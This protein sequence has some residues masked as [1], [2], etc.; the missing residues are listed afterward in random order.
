V[1]QPDPIQLDLDPTGYITG[2]NQATGATDQFGVSLRGSGAALAAIPIAMRAA[3]AHLPVAGFTVLAGLAGRTQQQMAP[4]KATTA[5]LGANFTVL[6]KGVEHLARQLPIGNAGAR[7]LVGTLASLG[8]VQKGQEVQTLNLAKAYVRLGAANNEGPAQL[9]IG[10]TQLARVTNTG[11]N[12]KRVEAIGDALTVV[13]AKSG[14][15][16]SGIL[17][18]SRLIAPMAAASGVGATKI[19]GI[20]AAFSKLGDDG[21]LGANAFN[22]MMGDLNRSVRDGSPMLATYA[23]IIG[24]TRADVL[25]MAKADPAEVITQVTEAVAKAGNLGPRM[26]EQLGLEGPRT[27]RV[28]QQLSSSGGLRQ[29]IADSVGGYGSGATKTGSD[30]ALRTLINNSE[31]FGSTLEQVTTS[32]GGPFLGALSRVVSI[33]GAGVGAV[34]GVVDS[35]PVQTLLKVFANAAIPLM[36]ALRFLGG[37]VKATFAGQVAT[38][39]PVRGL[40]GGFAGARESIAGTE[41]GRSV[42]GRLGGNAYNELVATG[43]DPGVGRMVG[44]NRAAER[45]G[46]RLGGLVSGTPGGGP[47]ILT[48]LRGAGVAA[49]AAYMKMEQETARLARTPFAER[50]FK[51]TPRGAAFDQFRGNQQ[52]YSY[53]RESGQMTVGEHMRASLANTRALSGVVGEEGLGANAR[54]LAGGFGRMAGSTAMSVGAGAITAG[55]KLLSG[56]GGPVG[57]GLT[58]AMFGVEGYQ[59]SQESTRQRD[60]DHANATT[61]ID[62]YRVA[63]GK[64]TQAT[65]TLAGAMSEAAKR[66]SS[67]GT[68]SLADIQTVAAQAGVKSR[69][70]DYS[71]MSVDA[72]RRQL[73]LQSSSGQLGPQ[74]LERIQQDLFLSGFNRHQVADAVKGISPGGGA[75]LQGD[76]TPQIASVVADQAKA[77]TEGG[78]RGFFRGVENALSGI[79]APGSKQ[80]GTIDVLTARTRKDAESTMAE[81]RTRLG[82]RAGAYGADYAQAQYAKEI[83][84]AVKAAYLMGNTD[85]AELY[86]KGYQKD[87]GLSN[88]HRLIDMGQVSRAGGSYTAALAAADKSYREGAYA[89][90]TSRPKA[91]AQQNWVNT[92]LSSTGNPLAALFDVHA[93]STTAGAVQRL[94]GP[95]GSPEDPTAQL[96]AQQAILAGAREAGTSMEALAASAR[97]AANSL[98]DVSDANSALLQ[99]QADIS[100]QI[101]ESQG[102]G[103]SQGSQ[104]QLRI[105]TAISQAQIIPVGQYG[106]AQHEAGVQATR[107]E[108]AGMQDTAKSLLTQYREQQVQRQRLQAD[109]TRQGVYAE[110]DYGTAVVRTVEQYGTSVVRTERNYLL[111]RGYAIAD[112]NRQQRYQAQDFAKQLRRAAEDGARA[113]Y[114]PYQRIQVQPTWDAGNMLGNLGEQ[115]QAIQRQL[116]N[117]GRLRRMGGKSNL[118]KLMGLDD[119]KNAQQ[120][121]TLVDDV[122]RDPH[123][124]GKLNAAANARQRLGGKLAGD[125]DNIPRQRAVE[126]QRIN[127]SRS[128]KVFAE[129]LARSAQAEKTTL[130]DMAADHA[131]TLGYMAD[132]RDRQVTRAVQ[133]YATMVERMKADIKRADSE[134]VD[135]AGSL[136]SDLD[137]ALK[138]QFVDFTD[139]S[140]S[141][142]KTA[143]DT[144]KTYGPQAAE[145][146]K[147]WGGLAPIPDSMPQPGSG[148][149]NTTSGAGHTMDLGSGSGPVKDTYKT[150]TSIIKEAFPKAHENADVGRKGKTVSGLTSLHTTGEAIDITPAT[151]KI[152]NWIAEHYPHSRELIYTPAFD[153]QLKDGHS[154]VYDEKVAAGHYDHIHW[155]MAMGGIATRPTKALIREGGSNEAIIP[156]NQRGVGVLVEAMRHFVNPE[157]VRALQASHGVMYVTYDHSSTHLDNRVMVEHVDL[158]A[159]TPRELANAL[160]AKARSDNL[161]AP[162]QRR[163]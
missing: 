46:A 66:L 126:D 80:K 162:P 117:L 1:T 58:A 119:P 136:T 142:I 14:A 130:A 15:S 108:Y 60:A 74:E 84:A 64:A 134:I 163:R 50:E 85:L 35:G 11:F 120:L 73:T 147:T 27:Q 97:G 23:Q 26:L 37:G 2:L 75:N 125:A 13:S 155:A 78:A 31:K 41:A 72:V 57:L 94:V 148:A 124:L 121:A 96:G 87:V 61:F 128:E 137:K 91:T 39:G 118:I 102:H 52:Y 99:R 122:A 33:S 144:L 103:G 17:G 127:I 157:D 8:Q 69:V 106:T 123:V 28:L 19:L 143:L 90:V 145:I 152:F 70:R 65:S 59:R 44:I 7:D 3:S 105:R 135:V 18:F 131:R 40:L 161:T 111:A 115:N 22:K 5:V 71:G 160:A 51:M 34:R 32:L 149:P 113:M 38:S 156:L 45:L 98:G 88:T 43:A 49:T 63:M 67:T 129:S 109:F 47:G 133:G 55:G 112:F 12:V 10:M 79:P 29:S 4:L 6:S 9:A 16:A 146:I 82:E 95:Q 107:T 158:K 153:R 154:F 53:L 150:E 116:S 83:D 138:G 20:S 77:P 36:L 24:R 30:A 42:A 86:Q 54:T 25:A 76:L 48:Q 110:Q 62:D 93:T 56:L 114:D 132:D 151:M 159:E 141:T 100:Q 81:M 21:A 89:D 92:T 104:A 101:A 139:H 68:H 140:T